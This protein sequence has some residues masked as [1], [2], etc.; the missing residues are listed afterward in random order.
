M[1][2]IQRPRRLR[3]S[4]AV[5]RLCRETRLSPDSLIYP[6]FVDEA[7]SGKRPIEA[8]PGQY[9]YGIDA[10]G[11]AVEECLAAG[12]THCILFGLPREKDACGSSAWAEHGVVQEAIRAIKARYPDFYVITDVCMCEYTD[13]G[14]C[15]ILDGHEVDNDKT[16]EVLAKTALSHAQAGADIAVGEG[17]PLGLPILGTEEIIRGI[18]REK[19][20]RFLQT[21]YTPEN[22][23]I[24]IAGAYDWQEAVDMLEKAFGAWRAGGAPVRNMPPAPALQNHFVRVKDVEQVQ[25]CVGYP[26]FAGNAP[27]SYAQLILSTLFGGSMSSRLF[28]SIRERN[29]LAYSVYSYVNV[30]SGAGEM[31]LY[32]GTSPETA[33]QVADLMGAEVRKLLREGIGRDEFEKARQSARISFVMGQESNTSRMRGNGNVLLLYDTTRSFEEILDKLERTTCDDVNDVAQRIFSAPFCTA[34]V[35]RAGQPLSFAAF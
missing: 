28:Q 26:A 27:E 5:R 15:G 3:G 17:H 1:E 2:L 31:E 35:G 4:D 18:T 11:E 19:L 24:S 6:I 20:F 34:V 16:L 12:V 8:L 21:H 30:Y 29:G 13:H 9:H 33:Q 23:V 32:A 7:L 25:L 10:V 14:H 22:T